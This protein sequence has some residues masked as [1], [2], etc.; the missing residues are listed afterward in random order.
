MVENLVA[1]L[2]GLTGWQMVFAILAL[3]IK[4]LEFGDTTIK[5]RSW[6]DVRRWLRRRS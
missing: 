2:A 3:R 6:K 4:A 1:L 5:F